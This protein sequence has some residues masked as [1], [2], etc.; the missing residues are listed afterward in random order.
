MIPN[1]TKK[2]PPVKNIK[3]W[4]NVF[5]PVDPFGYPAGEVF[6]Q[7]KDLKFNT[8][9][10]PLSAHGAYFF[11]PSFHGRLHKRLEELLK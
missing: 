8:G 10:S 2:V 9:A 5:D 7:V 1:C 3:R 4:V 6:E 11:T